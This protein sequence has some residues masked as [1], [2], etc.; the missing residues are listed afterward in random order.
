MGAGQHELG[1]RPSLLLRLRDPRDAESWREFAELYGPLVLR[2]LRRIGVSGDDAPDVAQ[3]VMQIVLKQMPRFDYD[4]AKGTFRGW[5]YTVTTNRARRFF[6]RQRRRP[7]ARGGTSNVEMVEGLPDAGAGMEEKWEREWQVRCLQAAIATV[8]PR[9]KGTTWRAF[10]M[11]VLEDRPP[12]E[13]A[14]ELGMSIGQVYVSKSRVLKR[15]SEA[16]EM[17]TT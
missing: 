11:A 5:L 7:P 16:V 10:E 9:V 1:T 17:V 3:E 12:A 6:A 13:V 15:L 2:Y 4:P 14:R 8:R